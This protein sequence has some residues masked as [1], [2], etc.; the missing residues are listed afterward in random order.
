LRSSLFIFLFFLIGCGNSSLNNSQKS[1]FDPVPKTKYVGYIEREFIKYG[2]VDIQTLSSR[3][4]VDLDYSD[5]SNFVHR[6]LYGNLE[7][8]FLNKET[9]AKLLAADSVLRSEFPQYHFLL[10]DGARPHYV[11]KLMYDLYRKMPVAQGLYLSHPD[12]N[13]LHNYGAA[14]DLTICDSNGKP[15]DMGTDFD[16][17]GH[18]SHIGDEWGLKSSGKISEEA[19]N[20][21]KLLRRI[22]LQAK[23]TPI[24]YE[25][26]H[27]NSCGRGYA[28]AHYTLIP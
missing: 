7:K 8:C 13:S 18:E 22:M 16:H 5:T 4:F 28:A 3:F 25:W 24:L 12:N 23:F 20:N 27:F 15:I 19:F 21:R 10:Y 14:I 9:A 6:D 11:Q 17:F 1:S 26:W 2:M